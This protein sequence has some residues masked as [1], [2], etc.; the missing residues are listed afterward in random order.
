MQKIYAIDAMAMIFRS[1]YALG[2]NFLMNSKGQNVTAVQ[3]FVEILLA[4]IEKEKPNKLVVVFDTMA[5]TFRSEEFEFYKANREDTPEDII[6]SIPIIKEIID[7]MGISRIELDGFEADDIIGTIAKQEANSDTSVYMVTP[8]KDYG[9][10]VE[11][12]IFRS[13][14]RR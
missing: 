8:D 5:P 4:L 10:L 7:A 13:E 9:Q 1:Y 2:K 12:N 3:K 14:E 11:E 6:W